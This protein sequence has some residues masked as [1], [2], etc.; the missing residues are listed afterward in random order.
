MA[1]TGSGL[2]VRLARRPEGVPAPDCFDVVSQPTPELAVGEVVVRNEFFSLDPYMRGRMSDARSYAA[3]YELGEIMHGDA[4]G[5][6]V[7]SGDPAIPVGA[8]VVHS[9]GWRAWSAGPAAR[10][11]VVDTAKLSPTAYLGPLGLPGFTAYVGMK[12]IAG[13]RE[14]DVVFVSAAAGAV[15]SLAGQVARQLGAG[16]VVG[17]AG[18]AA[19]V[20]LLTGDLGFD[21]AFNYKDGSLAGQ[22]RAAANGR[23]DVYFDNVGGE[24]LEVAIS[25]M[26]RSGRIALCGMI[27][28]YNETELPPGPSNL[29]ML[30]GKRLNVRGFLVSDHEDLRGE[31]E[32]AM[33]GWLTDGSVRTAETVVTGVEHAPQAFTSLFTGGNTGKLLV[34]VED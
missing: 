28:V 15:G 33:T 6:V 24:Q 16:R 3:P 29:G 5:R 18:S 32:Q 1:D 13:V 12:H 14:G 23:I 7:A 2:A 8:S 19:K 11:R 20:E 22:L 30:I 10:Y 27:S 21:A 17:S 31:F 26:A 4:V 9:D 25:A 34:R